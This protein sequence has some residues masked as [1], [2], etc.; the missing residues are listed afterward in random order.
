MYLGGLV[1]PAVCKKLRFGLHV[2]RCSSPYMH[3]EDLSSIALI[4]RTDLWS[5][6]TL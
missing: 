4:Q 5:S 3:V 6:T 2:F 1:A